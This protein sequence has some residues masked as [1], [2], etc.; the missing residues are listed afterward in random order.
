MKRKRMNKKAA[1]GAGLAALALVGGTFAYYSQSGTLENPLSTGRY[2]N[3]LVE[4]FTPLA[5]DMKPGTNWEKKV[6][7]QN[8]GDYPVLVRIRME[9][10]WV[11]KGENS[12]YKELDSIKNYDKFNV[13]DNISGTYPAMT[14]KAAQADDTDGQ[15][16][17]EDKTVVYKNFAAG[18]DWADGGDG[19]WYWNGVLEKKG[20]GKD[21]TDALM[22]GLVMAANI[23]LGKYETKEY[24]VVLAETETPDEDTEWTEFDE[25][26]LD[27]T[28]EDGI[29]DIR[30]IVIGEGNKL[31]RKSE[32]MI[33]AADEDGTVC[34]GYSDSNYTLTVTSEFVQATKDAVDAIWGLGALDRLDKVEVGADGVNL[35]NA[36]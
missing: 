21:T 19:Y 29:V 11:R 17:A 15:T 31:F 9:E 23:D 5:G 8:T 20:S 14:V 2:N 7:A 16:P 24:Y 18:T 6:G 10:K 27:D 25:A 13:V 34:L 35:V 1:A 36:E 12:A 26:D 4:E 3:Q 22:N 30:D 32:S 33:K 28:N